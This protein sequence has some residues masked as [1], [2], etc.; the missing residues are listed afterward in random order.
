MIGHSL[1]TNST[2][3]KPEPHRSR[4]HL[5]VACNAQQAEQRNRRQYVRRN[6]INGGFNILILTKNDC[7]QTNA[8]KTTGRFESSLTKISPKKIYF[9]MLTISKWRPI[10]FP[11]R[12]GL[13]SPPLPLLFLKIL[14]FF[15]EALITLFF[16]F[17]YK[18][19]LSFFLVI[20]QERKTV[21][22]FSSKIFWR[23]N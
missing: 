15:D 7:A 16:F 19:C 14:R 1:R 4:V 12:N 5:L 8:Q 6:L 13:H 3:S 17:F 20:Y 18:I 9:R 10:I 22:I 21:F 11:H 23:R 2:K